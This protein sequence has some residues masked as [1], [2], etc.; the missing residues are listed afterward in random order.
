MRIKFNSI[1]PI[2]MGIL[3]AALIAAGTMF[4]IRPAFFWR[5]ADI[6]AI[7]GLLIFCIYSIIAAFSHDT[8]KMRA[9]RF[10]CAG[11]SLIFAAFILIRPGFLAVALDITLGIWMILSAIIVLVNSFF[12]KKNSVARFWRGGITCALYLAGGI[13]LT[14]GKNHGAGFM[15]AVCGVY[16]VICGLNL[17]W[18]ANELRLGSDGKKGRRRVRIAVPV[19]IAA[20]LPS[21][22]LRKINNL[23]E[24]APDE[25]ETI[26]W[27][28]AKPSVDLEVF[29]HVHEGFIEGMGHCDICF[30]S[31]VYS[32]GNYDTKSC[33]LGGLIADGVLA[34]SPREG[35]IRHCL[36]F[37]GKTVIGFGLSLSDE[38]KRLVGEQINNLT[39]NAVRWLCPYERYLSGEISKDKNKFSDPASELFKDAG[40]RYYKFKKGSPF[41]TYFALGTNCV[42]LADHIVGSSGID[43]LR[44]GGII[45]PGTYLAYLNTLFERKNVLVSERTIYRS[46]LDNMKQA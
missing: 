37:E 6:A 11:A 28:E 15:G 7:S 17:L 31:S 21:R 23:I 32:Y 41:K 22:L 12:L 3:A 33:Y 2:Y 39:K 4:L 20:F 40:A 46:G 44:V 13:L 14:T 9:L 19:L 27:N 35:Y 1:S 38:Q 43:I 24:I 29:I 34:V 5:A 26:D 36:N 45:T 30:G 16:L 18:D 25:V 42:L 8:Q 10:I